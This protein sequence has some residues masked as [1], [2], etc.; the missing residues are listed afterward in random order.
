MSQYT[1][2]EL[3]ALITAQLPTNGTRQIRLLNVRNT[4]IGL[5]NARKPQVRIYS[6]YGDCQVDVHDDVV[7]INKSMN[8]DWTTVLMPASPITGK[9]YTIKDGRGDADINP[10][11]ITA[12]IDGSTQFYM[13]K[14]FGFITLYHN[15]TEWKTAHGRRNFPMLQMS[16]GWGLRRMNPLYDGKCLQ[17]SDGTNNTDIGFTGNGDIDLQAAATAIAAGQTGVKIWYDQSRNGNN[18][19]QNTFASM[20]TL[21]MGAAPNGRPVLRFAGNTAVK[22]T[23]AQSATINDIWPGGAYLLS[24]FRF[25]GAGQGGFGCLFAKGSTIFQY[26]SSTSARLSIDYNGALDCQ[27]NVTIALNTWYTMGIIYDSDTPPPDGPKPLILMDG[28]NGA[29]KA[30]DP[31][32]GSSYVS[33]AASSFIIGSSTGNA[34]MAGDL[35]TMVLFRDIPS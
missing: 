33:D 30:N 12:T 17:L 11:L 32:A 8:P 1:P 19:T 23:V 21:V 2:A 4:L 27:Y 29:T 7:E 35:T 28:V 18:A 25:T 15:G 20:P 6:D 26:R 5:M 9:M 22:L 10:I 13:N 34:G 14:P 16:A 31:S 3:A 24:H